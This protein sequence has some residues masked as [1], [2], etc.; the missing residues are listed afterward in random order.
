MNK[1]AKQIRRNLF[2]VKTKGIKLV[3]IKMKFLQ[4]LPCS[5]M[6]F[7]LGIIFRSRFGEKF[8][9]RHSIKAPDEMRRLHEQFY[10]Y[11]GIYGE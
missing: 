4:I 1:T 9:Y 8:M 5:I 3:P 6:G 7:I 2:N 10:N 11:I